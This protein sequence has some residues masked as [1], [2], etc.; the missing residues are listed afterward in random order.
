MT[1]RVGQQM[2]IVMVLLILTLFSAVF[3]IRPRVLN[4]PFRDVASIQWLHLGGL[5]QTYYTKYT[6]RPTMNCISNRVLWWIEA[7]IRKLISIWPITWVMYVCFTICQSQV[8]WGTLVWV[9]GSTWEMEHI[10]IHGNVLTTG[11]SHFS[12]WSCSCSSS[13]S[14]SSLPPMEPP[15][16]PPPVS[17]ESKT[18]GAII[19]LGSKQGEFRVERAREFFR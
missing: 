15:P 17:L 8:L 9:L 11:V 2:S 4:G 19:S 18:T 16:G 13:S 5:L 3:Y 12:W 14:S 6:Q 10:F 1:C 7:K